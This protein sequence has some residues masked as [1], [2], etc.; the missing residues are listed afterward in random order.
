MKQYTSVV[1]IYILIRY[2]HFNEEMP[3]QRVKGHII[4]QN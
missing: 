4:K 1:H 2:V 3:L